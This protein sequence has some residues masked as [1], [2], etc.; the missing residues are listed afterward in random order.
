MART[1][2][3]KSNGTGRYGSSGTAQSRVQ[4]RTP[5]VAADPT[6]AVLLAD[7]EIRL[8]MQADGVDE[9]ELLGL[10]QRVSAKL[11]RRGKGDGSSS[12]PDSAAYRPGVGII[13][14]NSRGEI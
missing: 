9:T 1:A 10:L 11:Q 12:D 8:V 5:L 2:S 3:G 4:R 13:L 6:L 14:L 7:P